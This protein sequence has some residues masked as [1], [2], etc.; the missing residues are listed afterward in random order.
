MANKKVIGI[1]GGMGPQASAR[2][3]DLLIKKSILVWRH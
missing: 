2:L 3:Y 1:L